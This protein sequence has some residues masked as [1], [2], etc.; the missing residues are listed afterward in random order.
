MHLSVS[1]RTET[2]NEGFLFTELFFDAGYDFGQHYSRIRI[3]DYESYSDVKLLKF[4]IHGPTTAA[5]WS[6]TFASEGKCKDAPGSI[7]L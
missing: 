4:N 2:V 1:H 7:H 3:F 5:N 6:L